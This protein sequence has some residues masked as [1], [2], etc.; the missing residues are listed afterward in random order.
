MQC[1]RS[2]NHHLYCERQE[3][4]NEVQ[5]FFTAIIETLRGDVYAKFHFEKL[6]YLFM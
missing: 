1:L 4:E 2:E 3:I 5:R 6:V